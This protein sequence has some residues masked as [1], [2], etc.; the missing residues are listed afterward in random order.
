MTL[1]FLP[2]SDDRMERE[3][4]RAGRRKEGRG[5]ERLAVIEGK[6]QISMEEVN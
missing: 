6:P 3:R 4:E 2:H 5:E 1:K